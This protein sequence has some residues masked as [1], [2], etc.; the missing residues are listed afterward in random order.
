[1]PERKIHFYRITDQLG[2]PLATPFDARPALQAVDELDF[3]A[4]EAHMETADGQV[5]LGKSLEYQQAQVPF[6]ALYRIRR[7]DL[8]SLET[9]GEIE[10]LELDADAG[11][12]EGIHAAFFA[13]S[14]V[15]IMYNH[16]G[17]RA[18]RVP[19]YLNARAG[20]DP[21][22]A[23]QPLIR[24]EIMQKVNQLSD[25][26]IVE[27]DAPIAMLDLIRESNE[28]LASALGAAR[29]I[30][31]PQRVSLRVRFQRNNEGITQR[32]RELIGQLVNDGRL[33]AFNKL[34][35]K[36]LNEMNDEREWIDILSERIT[37]T[38]DVV[39]RSDESRTIAD[40]S[41][42]QA[43]GD[44]YAASAD[45]INHIVAGQ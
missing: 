12:A 7:E 30:A 45:A 24:P 32:I 18:G 36:G 8:P 23:V 34:K 11:L 38:A 13:E 43:I 4:G 10:D 22:I 42:R 9:T 17:P 25:I 15:G 14:V 20:I 35:I 41:A 28:G 19:Q 1:M 33:H 3:A 6:M 44:A 5:L 26:T 31:T 16:F 39:T 40:E 37:V 21:R 27:I 2:Q 29:R